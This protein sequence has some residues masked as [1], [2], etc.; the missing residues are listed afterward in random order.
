MFS[1]EF[2]K[3][4][5]LPFLWSV[6]LF[7]L[8][9]QSCGS[10]TN[11]DSKLAG[12]ASA[13]SNR[14]GTLGGG[15]DL[16]REEWKGD[17]VT[18][19]QA[20][21]GQQEATVRFDKSVSESETASSLGFSLDAKARYGVYEGDLAADFARS[22]SSNAYSESATYT[23]IYKFKNL[24]FDNAKLSTV[25]EKAHKAGPDQFIK[26]CGHEFVTQTQIGA[27]FM[28]NIK[29]EFSSAAEKQSF[30]ANIG[31]KG[32]AF[33]VRSKLESAKKSLSKSA[34]VT[35][36]I[37]QQG[38][39]I[40]RITSGIGSKT[41][42]N[43][44]TGQKEASSLM[45][46]SMENLN[47][48]LEVLDGAISYATDTTEG[49]NSF[50]NQLNFEKIDF[51]SPNGPATLGYI[52]APYADIAVYPPDPITLADLKDSREGLFRAFEKQLGYKN[53]IEALQSGAVRL[54][55]RQN[56]FFEDRL[57]NV[58]TDTGK[59]VDAGK[60]C[61]SDFD[62]CS[63][64][65]KVTLKEHNPNYL[66]ED[67]DVAPESFAQ[68]CDISRLPVYQISMKK[69]VDALMAFAQLD[70]NTAGEDPCKQANS[71]LSNATS[72]DLE[73]KD[74][75]TLEP[76]APFSTLKKLN[77]RKNK[78]S[79]L[80]GLE[81]MKELE[82]L[83][84]SSNSVSDLKPIEKLKKLKE[85]VAYGNN[86]QPTSI[87]TNVQKIKTLLL[88]KNA[89]CDFGR[90]EALRR[91]LV[92]QAQLEQYTSLNFA[93]EFDIQLDTESPVHGWGLCSAAY[94]SIR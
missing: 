90:K 18:G 60:V 33:N 64:L 76:L 74:L 48:C 4:S 62:K 40:S 24:R 91:G 8:A 46:C 86:V 30:S 68:W 65:S 49:A 56:T 19:E 15:W 36:R 11:I 81:G 83:N 57:A 6:P 67:F 58:L 23:S 29:M 59:I 39:N 63:D 5:R 88:D 37:Y 66:E 34:S 75:V 45:S 28:V 80:K 35:V 31:L 27:R 10:A 70:W 32:P 20:F 79:S 12:G 87:P 82:Q 92:A 85:L 43:A 53:R 26:T 47:A 22:A 72:I 84:I 42:T 50:P 44:Q 2:Y 73:G 38:G 41:S 14:T 51:S 55:P 16:D 89:V 25:G 21:E 1:N 54:S 9:L 61:Y 3:K 7:A 13:K 94:D 69:T 78:I 71:V 52:T 77:V 17:C 93:P